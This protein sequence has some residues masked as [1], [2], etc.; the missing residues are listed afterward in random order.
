MA[1]KT[2]APKLTPQQAFYALQKQHGPCV[3]K[4]KDG[5]GHNVGYRFRGKDGSETEVMKSTL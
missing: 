3:G 1:R 4:I 2:A 5:A